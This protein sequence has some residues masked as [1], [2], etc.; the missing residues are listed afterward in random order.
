[1]T[2]REPCRAETVF[3]LLALAGA[4]LPFLEVCGHSWSLFQIFTDA[5]L[6]VL[7]WE[8]LALQLLLVLAALDGCRCLLLL[9]GLLLTWN[10]GC[11]AAGIASAVGG[12]TLLRHL[13]AGAWCC[14]AGDA[15]L[16]ASVLHSEKCPEK[17]QGRAP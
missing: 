7:A 8:N 11:V 12:E 10:L 6:R 15:G 4:G 13:A 1:M 9:G 16:L 5:G 14:F 17:C 3:S 2:G